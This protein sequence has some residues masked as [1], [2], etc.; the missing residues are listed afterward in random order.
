MN[1]VLAIIG[2]PLY[3]ILSGLLEPKYYKNVLAYINS[4]SFQPL[5]FYF[6]NKTEVRLGGRRRDC[7]VE[8]VIL[9]FGYLSDSG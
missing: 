1:E 8:S 3:S 7:L 4:V 2:S 9:S 5:L 6:S